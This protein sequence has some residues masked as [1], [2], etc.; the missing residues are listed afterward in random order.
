MNCSDNQA[1]ALHLPDGLGKHLLA[2]SSNQL[3][4]PC[5]AHRPVLLENLKDEHRPFVRHAL[6]DLPDECL[7]LWINLFWKMVLPG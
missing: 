5:E 1:V 4:K 6:D 3:T 2:D 7:D